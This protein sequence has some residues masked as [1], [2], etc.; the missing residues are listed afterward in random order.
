M[1]HKRAYSVIRAA[2]AFGVAVLGPLLAN[3]TSHN[4]RHLSISSALA[5]ELQAD[6]LVAGEGVSLE[7]VRKTITVD[8]HQN[9]AIF[10]PEITPPTLLWRDANTSAKS[11]RIDVTFADGSKP[12]RVESRGEGMKI[13][14]IDP[15]CVSEN[16]RPPSLTPEQAAAHTWTPDVDT[17]TRIKQHSVEKGATVS[18]TGRG[19]ESADVAVSS[20]QVTLSTSRDP[21]GAPIFYRD[22][23]LMP[24]AG[25]KNIIQPLAPA[26]I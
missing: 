16:N 14:E 24:S 26:S 9:V 25:E 7:V 5:A 20:G 6:P 22:V 11:W 21:V 4:F 12:I 1:R 3:W 17:W 10:P 19:A 2:T 13:G 8:Y 23:P 15:R 18:I